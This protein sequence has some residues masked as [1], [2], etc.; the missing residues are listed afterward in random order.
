[1]CRWRDVVG[2]EGI[3]QISD[4]GFLKRCKYTIK[5]KNGKT[6]I[7][8]PKIVKPSIH[9]RGYNAGLFKNGICKTEYIHRLVAQ[10]FIPNP[11]GYTYVIHLNGCKFDNR[12]ENLA[13]ID[14][15][16]YQKYKHNFNKCG[17]N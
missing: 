13:W 4:D 9:H 3:Y 11:Y 7:K 5:C 17:S 15:G 10:A 16:Y 2:Y 6:R 14:R 1:M 8:Y 12:V